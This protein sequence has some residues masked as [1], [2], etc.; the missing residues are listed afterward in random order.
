[1]D[2]APLPG[3]NA[4][5][6]GPLAIGDIKYKTEV[7]PLQA[8]ARL[9]QAGSLRLPRRLRAGADADHLTAATVLIAALSGRGLAA[10]ARRAGYLPLVADAFGDSDTREHAA[11]SRCVT[12]AARIGFRAKP[13]LAAL[14]ALEAAA[15]APPIGLVLGSGFED[16]PE[17]HRRAVAP[18]SAASATTPRQIARAKNP[19]GAV[20]P[21]RHARHRAPRDAARPAERCAPAGC[22]SASAAAA[23]RTSSPRPRP[24]RSARRYF[25]R[26][27]DGEPFSVLAVAAR[28]GVQIVGISRQWTVGTGPRPYRYGGAVGPV[29]LDA[30]HRCRH[31]YGGRAGLRRPRSRRPRLLRLPACRR[32]PSPVGGQ[33]APQRHARRVRRR[34]AARC[35]AAHLA[36]CAGRTAAAPRVAGAPRRGHPLRRPWP[37]GDRRRPLARVDRRPARPR[38]PHPA[39]PPDRHRLRR[40]RQPPKPPSRAAADA[41][42]NWRRCCMHR[43][44]TGSETTMQ[45]YNGPAPSVSARAAKLVDGIV[46]DASALRCVSDDR[47]GGRAADRPRRRSAGRP[48]SR[49]PP[50]RSLHGR[51]RH[52]SLHM[53]SRLKRWPLGRHRARL[54]PGHRLP[55]QPVCRL[56]DHRAGERLLRARLRPGARPVARRGAVQG[57]RLRRPLQQGFARHR[58]RQGRRPRRSSAQIAAACGVQP[59]D[60]T[61]LFAPT[62]SLAGTVQIAARVLEVALHKAHELHFP[63]EHIEDGIGTAP[64]APPVPDFIKAMGRTNDAIIYGG[65]VQLFVRGADEAAQKLAQ[66]TAELDVL[67][68]RPAVRRD[69][70]GRRRRLLQ[71]RSHVVQPRR[72]DR[73]QP[74]HRRLLPCGRACSRHRRRKLPLSSP[75]SGPAHRALPR[76]GERQ[77][78]RAPPRRGDARARRR[79]RRQS[80]PRCAFDTQLASGIDIPGFDG[81]LPD[82]V[83][84][85]SISPGTLEQITFRLGLL[86]AL[87]ESGVRVWNDARAIERC[88]D[89]SATTFLLHKAGIPTP[90]TRTMEG[91]APADGLRAERRPAADLQAAVRLAGQRPAARRRCTPNCRPPRPPTTSTTCRTSCRLRRRASRTGASSSRAAASSPPWRAAPAHWIT[92]VHQGG[93]PSA[94]EPSE[95]MAQ[96]AAG[97]ARR[98]RRRLRRRRSHP[99]AR[100]AAAGARGEQQSVLARAAERLRRQHRR[101]HR[102][103]LPP[104]R[105]RAPRQR[106]EPSPNHAPPERGANR[107][108]CSS[109]PAAP[110]S[111][112]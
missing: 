27:L 53:S 81:A 64:I 5:G 41:W 47:R 25:Q 103:G 96:L 105:R 62:G 48:R 49:P 108:S 43:R 29:R 66:T 7:R 79:R 99:H 14:A 21:A 45:K 23:A 77:L 102:R 32:H 16:R 93:S 100:R 9:R 101:S 65:R 55:R 3:C 26:R 36:A 10:S 51:P 109:P 22:R 33:P 89:K 98:R 111:P 8:H 59:A 88:V 12:D 13:V 50:R 84:V 37:A 106:H 17:A 35:S 76:G 92:N 72:G 18:L 19:T 61:I 63:L 85:R 20:R 6:V 107:A 87:R 4:L 80:L 44:Q 69:L 28:D 90:R 38:H 95:E 91:H 24:R 31:A 11:A 15:A 78:A 75:A 40:R 58:G 82:A 73:F 112:R 60:L 71:N 86:H 57:P 2:G 67:R 52:G 1:M 97:G 74:R 34:R 42:T 94:H 104:R 70:R 83:F 56:D 46:A 54:Q 30:C 39:L 68:L 110:S